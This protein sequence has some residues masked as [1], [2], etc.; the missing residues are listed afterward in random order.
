VDTLDWIQG[1]SGDGLEALSH[2]VLD[3]IYS[4]SQIVFECAFRL[5]LEIYQRAILQIRQGEHGK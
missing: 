4:L 5:V 1:L 3:N 2:Q